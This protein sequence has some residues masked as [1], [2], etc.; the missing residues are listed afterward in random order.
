MPTRILAK[1]ETCPFCWL[2][3]ISYD[4]GY[5]LPTT[6]WSEAGFSAKEKGRNLVFLNEDTAVT[7]HGSARLVQ[8]TIDPSLMRKWL[9]L[10][11]RHHTGLCTPAAVLKTPENPD[12]LDVLRV[13]DVQEGCIVEATPGVRYLAL[14]YVW[15]E[16]IPSVRLQKDNRAALGIP[17]GLWEILPRLPLTI[18]DALH[19]VELLSERFLWVDSLCLVQDDLEDMRQGIAKMDLVY[20]GAVTTIIA[21]TGDNAH[22]GLPGLREGSRCVKQ[23]VVEMMEGVKMTIT[24]GVYS[25]LSQSRYNTRGWT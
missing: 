5:P 8:P 7:P 18:Q 16:I 9:E 14:S 24:R 11:E 25:A 17:G 4:G 13:I 3:E 23:I 12:G 10:C 1:R 19:L 20:K 2:I 21:G 15:G 6:N 22:A